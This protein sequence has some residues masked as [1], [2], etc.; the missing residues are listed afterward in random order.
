[1]I[2]SISRFI[3]RRKCISH[4]EF[5]RYKKS[6]KALLE[7]KDR[8]ISELKEEKEALMKAAVKQGSRNYDLKRRL[9]RLADKK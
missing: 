3:S 2:K 6:V 1:M 7:R 9:E 5:M 4:V 8:E